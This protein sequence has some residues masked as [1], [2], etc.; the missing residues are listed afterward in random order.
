MNAGRVAH[1][2][3]GSRAL[4]R[5]ADRVYARFLALAAI[6][7]VLPWMLFALH[8]GP[9]MLR[10]A[11][12]WGMVWLGVGILPVLAASW[13]LVRK[14]AATA[15]LLRWCQDRQ[16]PLPDKVRACMVRLG[17]HEGQ[18]IMYADARP[19]V[20]TAGWLAPRVYLS[21]GCVQLL[22]EDELALVLAHEQHHVRSRDPLRAAF[23][24][25]MA[26]AWRLLPVL[27]QAFRQYRQ[28]QEIAADAWAL[29][30]ALPGPGAAGGDADSLQRRLDLAAVVIKLWSAARRAP[31]IDGVSAAFTDMPD[32][33]TWLLQGENPLCAP[34]RFDG[35]AQSAVLVATFVSAYLII[36]PIS[37]AI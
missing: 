33:L 29:E 31:V 8:G 13:T 20:F 5:A 30:R 32:R 2:P 24:G 36:C 6:P 22:E 1:V 4:A 18:C 37:P 35:W 10:G 3:M 15:T 17:L 16:L 28:L 11:H 23:A 27:P 26:E 14:A 12:L 9:A 34:A 19:S 21:A 7:A 25:A